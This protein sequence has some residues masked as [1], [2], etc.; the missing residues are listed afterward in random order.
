MMPPPGQQ[1]VDP[2]PDAEALATPD[3]EAAVAMTAAEAASRAPETTDQRARREAQE[4]DLEKAA[5]QRLLDKHVVTREQYDAGVALV[6]QMGAGLVGPNPTE[7]HGDGGD[8]ESVARGSPPVSPPPPA[9]TP[10]P[11]R[12]MYYLPRGLTSNCEFTMDKARWFAE[13][14]RVQ[15]LML[16]D[17]FMQMDGDRFDHLFYIDEYFVGKS[18]G[19]CSAGGAEFDVKRWHTDGDNVTGAVC[20]AASSDNPCLWDAVDEFRSSGSHSSPRFGD[21][22]GGSAGQ[23]D[24]IYDSWKDVPAEYSGKIYVANTF[25][26]CIPKDGVNGKEAGGECLP[27]FGA[28][29]K[30][31]V[32]RD[33]L[34]DIAKDI[35]FHQMNLKN[36][37]CL[38]WRQGDFV[39]TKN[40]NFVDNATHAGHMTANFLRQTKRQST[41]PVNDLVITTNDDTPIDR[42]SELKTT[43]RERGINSYMLSD[44]TG[45]VDGFTRMYL[46]KLACAMADNYIGVEGSSFS[47]SILA[48]RMSCSAESGI[49]CKNDTPLIAKTG[50]N[51]YESRDALF[52]REDPV[53]ASGANTCPYVHCHLGPGR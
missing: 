50:P 19:R 40:A 10:V 2:S 48:L 52:H 8:A 21:G 4:R 37:A 15:T 39:G 51:S 43:L 34:R 6:D 9:L 53:D 35:V 33:N 23:W 25:D 7:E 24:A 31:P 26:A 12:T 45:H 5:L 22:K 47:E 3:V 49:P 30:Q 46:G 29:E 41:P 42:I 17:C 1:T 38:H 36:Y 11:E 16:P 28:C 14:L 27:W 13:R 18:M 20:V 32:F 44:Y